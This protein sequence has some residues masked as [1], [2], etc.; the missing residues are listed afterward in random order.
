MCDLITRVKLGHPTIIDATQDLISNSMSVMAIVNV[1][2]LT[3]QILEVFV[4][5]IEETL[6]TEGFVLHV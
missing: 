1:T 4:E 6:V 2:V 5:D 3:I